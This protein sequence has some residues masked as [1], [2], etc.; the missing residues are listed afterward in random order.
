[1]SKQTTKPYGESP[2]QSI[3]IISEGTK[4]K[5]DIIA[6]GDIRIDGEL[7]G[8]ISAKGRLVVGPNG[9]ITG[10]IDCNNIEVSGFIKGKI[11]ASELLNMKSTSQIE[12]DII[13]GKLSVE[14]GS[15]FSGTCSMGGSTQTNGT[16]K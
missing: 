16:E 3:N 14:P 7:V 1:M 11:K 2:N 12:G 4:I 13:A 5:G 9:R 6:S 15:V 10:E 8:N